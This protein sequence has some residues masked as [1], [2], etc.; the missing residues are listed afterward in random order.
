MRTRASDAPR[1][2]NTFAGVSTSC[3]SAKEVTSVDDVIRAV[4][5]YYDGGL[6][7]PL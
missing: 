1:S 4:E 2:S 7:P 5:R 6:L 3:R